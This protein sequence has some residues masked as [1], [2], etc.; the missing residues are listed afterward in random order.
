MGWWTL[1]F[2]LN[3]HNNDHDHDNR[4]A[5]I[6]RVNKWDTIIIMLNPLTGVYCYSYIS[7]CNVHNVILRDF[8]EALLLMLRKLLC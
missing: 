5:N 6:G 3:R 4:T 8:D 1:S 2:F 7:P